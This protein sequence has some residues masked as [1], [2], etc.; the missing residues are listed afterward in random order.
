MKIPKYH[1]HYLTR[2]RAESETDSDCV[3]D[4]LQHLVISTVDSDVETSERR[5]YPESR[6]PT[7]GVRKGYRNPL[8]PQLCAECGH[9][10]GHQTASETSGRDKPLSSDPLTLNQTLFDDTRHPIQPSRAR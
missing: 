9:D 7:C 1:R 2:K 4:G 5:H 8:A 3:P 6:C 10:Y